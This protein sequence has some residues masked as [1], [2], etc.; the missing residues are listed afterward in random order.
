MLGECSFV[1]LQNASTSVGDTTPID[2]VDLQ[3]ELYV[4]LY[5][6]EGVECWIIERAII[7][8]T[9]RQ[10]NLMNHYCIGRPMENITGKTRLLYL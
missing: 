1:T 2:L 6:I 7:E 10:A 3:F 8:P 5:Y 9:K 4:Y